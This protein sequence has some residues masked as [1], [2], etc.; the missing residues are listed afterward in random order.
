[1]SDRTFDPLRA[2]TPV[3]FAELSPAPGPGADLSTPAPLLTARAAYPTDSV[4]ENFMAFARE[5]SESEDSMLIGAVLPVVSRLLAR[6]VFINF[7]G[8]KY[9]N[10][11]PVE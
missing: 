8:R 7:A 10:Q 4:L 5:Y 11:F 9:P 2:Y 3:E 6:R 1:M